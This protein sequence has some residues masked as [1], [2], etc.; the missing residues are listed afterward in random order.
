MTV[1]APLYRPRGPLRE[2]LFIARPNRFVVDVDMEGQ[3]VR[4]YLPNPGRLDELLHPGAPLRL[5]AAPGGATEWTVVAAE[6][7]GRPV[8]VHTHWNNDVAQ[9]L[10]E[11]GLVP[12]LEEAQI[13]RREVTEGSS[14]FDFLLD[15]A[16]G[17][18]VMEVKSCTLFT[19]SAAL[20]P[21][22]VTERG[23]RHLRHLARLAEEGRRSALLFVVHSDRPR[24]FSPEYHRDLLFART[25][26]EVRDRVEIMALAVSWQEDL[27]L[28]RDVRPLPIPWERIEAEARDGGNYLLL[29][30]ADGP[31]FLSD[32]SGTLPF[33]RGF[34]LYVG[35]AEREMTARMESHRRRRKTLRSPVDG[36]REKTA[37]VAAM[38]LR[39]SG[40]FDDALVAMLEALGGRP[41][42]LFGDGP[43]FGFDGDPRDGAFA[44]RFLALSTE[45]LLGD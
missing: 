41:C 18:L 30:R 33:D 1:S 35:S 25:L 13:L 3:S 28:S 24:L 44:E 43:L 36:L 31:F 32:G 22:A 7:F 42:P 19:E 17:P 38:A 21:D 15:T 9:A 10:V 8:L 39:G 5:V 34:Y 26:L 14:R 29:L 37:F 12:G 16:S 11:K 40:R 4:A 45:R 6:R 20:F 27:S 23:S 2:G